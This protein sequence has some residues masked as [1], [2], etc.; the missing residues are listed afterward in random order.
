LAK[1]KETADKKAPAAAVSGGEATPAAAKPATKSLKKPKL[2]PK[3]K[4]RLPRRQ[5]KAAGRQ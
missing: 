3:N 4:S 1:Q 5:K 2:A